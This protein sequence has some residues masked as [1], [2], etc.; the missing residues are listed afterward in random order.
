MKNNE[1]NMYNEHM[2]NRA[3]EAL[4]AGLQSSTEL[5][6]TERILKLDRDTKLLGLSWDEVATEINLEMDHKPILANTKRHGITK[7]QEP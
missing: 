7:L 4:Y 5:D 6:G 2:T 1:I 3:M